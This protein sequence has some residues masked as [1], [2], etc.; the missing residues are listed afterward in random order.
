MVLLG[1]PVP[2]PLVTVPACP[3]PPSSRS[4]SSRVRP[5]TRLS[6]RSTSHRPVRFLP[7]GSRRLPLMRPSSRR[8]LRRNM[9]LPMSPQPLL[10]EK[11]LLVSLHNNNQLTAR[12][13]T[14]LLNRR[15][16]MLLRKSKHL[17]KDRHKELQKKT[18]KSRVL[19]ACL[20]SVRFSNIVMGALL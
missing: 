15:L 1:V 10:L 19:V 6:P 5:S 17:D 20:Q 2:S 9:I 13:P 14:H 16:P 4:L 3:A 7:P 12:L 18:R 8:Q 11:H